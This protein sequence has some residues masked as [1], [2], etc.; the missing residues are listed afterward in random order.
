[1]RRPALPG[2][3]STSSWTRRVPFPQNASI[4]DFTGRVA[5]TT[6]P[7]THRVDLPQ[8][9]PGVDLHRGRTV[10]ASRTRTTFRRKP[11]TA[12]QRLPRGRAVSTFLMDAS[13]ILE[14][15]RRPSS[16]TGVDFL[17]DQRRLRRG[18]APHRLFEGHMTRRIHRGQPGVDLPRG[19]TARTTSRRTRGAWTSPRTYGAYHFLWTPRRRPSSRSR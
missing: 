15:G 4:V 10:S 9:P 12:S 19:C 3:A 14:D 5:R 2:Q 16:R 6:W 1:M 17:K 7:K 13:T 8:A 18:R 11:R